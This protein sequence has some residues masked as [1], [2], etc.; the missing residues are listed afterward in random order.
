MYKLHRSRRTWLLITL[1]IGCFS[2]AATAGV[3]GAS[4][5]APRTADG[6]PDLSGTYDT[7]TLTPLVR[8]AKFGDQLF[9]TAEQAQEIE[10]AER[11]L[12]EN[13]L[14][15]TDP[16][17][18]A[19]P[20]GGSPPVGYQDQDREV[21]GSGN[22]G[23]YNSVWI[24][25][26]E[27]AVAVDGL[28]RTSIITDPKNGQQPALTEAGEARMARRFASF[29]RGNDGSAWWVDEASHGP[30]DDPEDRPLPERCLLGFGSTQGPPMLPVLYNNHKRIVQTED[31]VMILVEMVHDAR[32]IRIG[33]QGSG[34]GT[35]E[36]GPPE[37]RRWLGD[38]IGHWEGDTLV[39]DTVHFTAQ[40]GLTAASQD[41][42]VV[43]RFTRIDQDTL[44]YEFTVDDPDTWTAPWS[45]SYTWPA[46]SERMFEYGCHEGNYALS[47][48]LKGARLL[49]AEALAKR[50]S[51]K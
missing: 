22:V 40:P 18:E 50:G 44:H 35:I 43:E 23:G 4:G 6:R 38:S 48:V 45:G 8:S 3:A 51:G 25:R 46:T 14:L 16:D 30:Y 24:D 7:A 49:E 41:L 42:H 34:Q 15:A 47:A 9:L 31:Y 1:A 20:V 32:I 13:T 19:P 37:I 33:D 28:F 39:V 17:R 21:W 36:H 2:M 27:R 29:R 12:V 10:D 26:G 5:K 11:R